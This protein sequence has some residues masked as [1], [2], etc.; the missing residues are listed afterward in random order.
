MIWGGYLELFIILFSSKTKMFQ[1]EYKLISLL[2]I[3][4]SLRSEKLNYTGFK[5]YR[6]LITNRN[7]LEHLKNVTSDNNLS[8]LSQRMYLNNSQNV[9]IMCSPEQCSN[10]SLELGGNIALTEIIN[11]IQVY[12]EVLSL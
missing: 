10:L 6:A 3:I 7:H 12:N 5:V 9:D 4:G 8:I 2:L 11:D 1:N